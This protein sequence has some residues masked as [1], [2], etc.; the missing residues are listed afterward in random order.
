MTYLI[1]LKQYVDINQI[2]LF[3]MITRKIHGEIEQKRVGKI[4]FTVYEGYGNKCNC[5]G[6]TNWL[7]FTIDHVNNDGYKDRAYPYNRINR[8]SGEPLYKRIIE[9]KFPKNYQILCYNCNMG[10]HRNKGICPH[11]GI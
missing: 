9:Q 1:L 3:K 11:K 2:Y 10:K 5:C 8:V 4:R 7:F 6:E